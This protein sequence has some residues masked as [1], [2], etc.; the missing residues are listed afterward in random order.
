MQVSLKWLRDYVDVDVPPAE[1][2]ERLTM[3]GLEVDSISEMAPAFCGVR[4]N[5]LS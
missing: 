2:A 4:A 1:L 3:A 5:N